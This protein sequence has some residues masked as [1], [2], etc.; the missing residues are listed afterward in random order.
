[1]SSLFEA[2]HVGLPRFSGYVGREIL[3]PSLVLNLRLRVAELF[4]WGMLV[5]PLG[6][7]GFYPA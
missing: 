5:R 6:D 7:R 1:M 4:T 2:T 3:A